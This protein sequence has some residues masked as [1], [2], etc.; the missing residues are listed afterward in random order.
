MRTPSPEDR[1]ASRG[2]R[3]HGAVLGRRRIRSPLKL[4]QPPGSLCA[5]GG[6]F[7]QRRDGRRLSWAGTGRP[8]VEPDQQL[9]DGLVEPRDR[10]ELVLAQVR[11]DPAMDD[12]NANF[13]LGFVPGSTRQRRNDCHAVVLALRRYFNLMPI[14]VPNYNRETDRLQFGT[15]SA[16][17][18]PVPT[19]E[20]A[21]KPVEWLGAKDGAFRRL[22][23]PVSLPKHDFPP[24]GVL[25]AHVR[26][27]ETAR[28]TATWRM[29]GAW[30]QVGKLPG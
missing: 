25:T 6:R 1:R 19:F 22:T 12:L 16:C 11:H 8:L 7:R 14:T 26:W 10:E 2:R 5:C 29:G 9:G 15:L 4:W 23:L 3:P 27:R 28:C 20:R 30:N 18:C 21:A 24:G 13:S 17:L